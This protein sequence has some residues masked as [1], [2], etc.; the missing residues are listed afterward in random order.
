MLFILCVKNGRIK[1]NKMVDSKMFFL[2][3]FFFVY[4]PH[5]EWAFWFASFLWMSRF[6]WGAF[7][8]HFYIWTDADHWI[9]CV[10]RIKTN[11]FE[12]S[13]TEWT[14][15][16][17]NQNASVWF[18][19]LWR[20][21]VFVSCTAHVRHVKYCSPFELTADY[22]Y[23]GLIKGKVGFSTAVKCIRHQ[24]VHLSGII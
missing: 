8:Q 22:K 19:T 5:C 17:L 9:S 15:H 10:Q 4:S 12:V 14:N 21:K 13:K 23:S 3:S 6:V 16:R 24:Y 20:K 7:R 1:G 18:W 2:R 11:L